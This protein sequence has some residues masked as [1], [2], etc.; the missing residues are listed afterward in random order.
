MYLMLTGFLQAAALMSTVGV[1]A[2]DTAEEVTAYNTAMLPLVSVYAEI[3]DQ[4][5]YEPAVDQDMDFSRSTF[6]SLIATSRE[7]GIRADLL[8]RVK[9]L[10][11]EAAAT[12]HGAADWPRVIESL[13]IR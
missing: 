4:A 3:I 5:K 1:S 11:D 2:A 12:G 10:V 7:Q 9:K 13:H 8:E 6:G